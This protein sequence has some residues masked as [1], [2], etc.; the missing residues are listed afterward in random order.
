MKKLTSEWVN[1]CDFEEINEWK[2]GEPNMSF[3]QQVVEEEVEGICKWMTES[4]LSRNE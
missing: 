2:L 1:K 3:G 4:V